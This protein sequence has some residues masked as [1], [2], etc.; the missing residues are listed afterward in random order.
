MRGHRT[1]S[2]HRALVLFSSF[3][4]LLLTAPFLEISAKERINVTFAFHHLVHEIRRE[5]GLADGD[6][7]FGEEPEESYD[8]GGDVEDDEEE[9]DFTASPARCPP[10]PPRQYEVVPSSG[11]NLFDGTTPQRLTPAEQK[12][13]DKRAKRKLKKSEKSEKNKEKKSKKSRKVKCA[14]M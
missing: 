9:D 12:K 8:D 14:I 11:V 2:E 7:Q 13:L 10:L 3:F 6:I 1:F 5:K 4:Y